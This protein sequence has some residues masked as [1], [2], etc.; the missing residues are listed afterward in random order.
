MPNSGSPQYK[1]EIVHFVPWRRYLFRGAGLSILLV[2]FVLIYHAG[3]K[4][5]E[6]W[7]DSL[8]QKNIEQRAQLVQLEKK[9]TTLRRQH[10]ASALEVELGTRANEALRKDLVEAERAL[11]DLEE[12][13]AFYKGLMDPTMD[14]EVNFRSVQ[15]A[16]GLLPEDLII[17]GVVQQ[18]T[19]NH[20]LVKGS[21][22]IWIEGVQSRI[23]DKGDQVDVVRK[24]NIQE[25]GVDKSVGLRFKYF[26]NFSFNVKLPSNFVAKTLYLKAET[27]KNKSF[28]SELVWADLLK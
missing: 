24:L 18:L 28:E 20:K 9:Y 11:A 5:G 4:S 7:R 16:Q 19:L 26:Q 22:E 8:Q 2:V 21:L 15:L 6:A 1:T 17:T 3:G 12:Q 23:D 14:D 13:I 27:D 25:L 10:S